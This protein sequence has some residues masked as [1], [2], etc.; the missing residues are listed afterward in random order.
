MGCDI[1]GCLRGYR[2]LSC[3]LV[4][5]FCAFCV[6]IIKKNNFLKVFCRWVMVQF[7]LALSHSTHL[8]KLFRKQFWQKKESLML[9]SEA[10]KNKNWSVNKIFIRSGKFREQNFSLNLFSST[11]LL[12]LLRNLC[13]ILLLLSLRCRAFLMPFLQNFFHTSMLCNIPRVGK[14]E[15][16][17]WE[18]KST[19]E[20][21]HEQKQKSKNFP[22][23]TFCSK[24]NFSQM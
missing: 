9:L 19:G 1:K 20:W 4:F 16:V 8:Q 18:V 17:E 24:L 2:V 10:L 15:N 22:N 14:K 3:R 12:A 21:I 5:P 11:L 7:V 13:L 23:Y 6:T